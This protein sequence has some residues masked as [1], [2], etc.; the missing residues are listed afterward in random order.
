[1]HPGRVE[2]GL[3]RVKE[4]GAMSVQESVGE[5]VGL[6]ESA[7]DRGIVGGLLIDLGDDI[8]W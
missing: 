5:M 6:I 1:M 2:T 4:D 3:V 7:G 8:P